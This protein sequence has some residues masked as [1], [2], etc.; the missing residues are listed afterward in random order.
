MP[1]KLQTIKNHTRNQWHYIVVIFFGIIL[2]VG[3]WGDITTYLVGDDSAF[4][5]ARLQ[6][7]PPAIKNGQILAQVSPY[8]MF[9]YGYGYNLFYGPLLP[10]CATILRAVFQSWPVAI[11]V[12][13]VALLVISGIFTSYLVYKAS[14]KRTLAALAGIF[15]MAA[16][17][18]LL[19]LYERFAIGEFAAMTFFPLLMLGLYQLVGHQPHAVR[20]ITISASV[21]LLTH[22]LSVVLAVLMTLM[23]LLSNIK[24][25]W[26][27]ASFKKMLVAGGLALGA[28]A[29]YLLPLA[30]LKLVGNYGVF[31]KMYSELRLETNPEKISEH[32]LSAPEIIYSDYDN[33]TAIE[34]KMAIGIIA[35]I[36]LS[37]YLFIRKNISNKGER[38]LIDALYVISIV[39][40]LMTTTVVNWN[41]VSGIL[42]SIQFPWRFLSVFSFTISIV[43]AYVFYYI[44][45]DLSEQ[46]QQCLTIIIGLIAVC[47]VN[48]IY[49]LP[50]VEHLQKK[51]EQIFSLEQG[52]AG[53]SGEYAPVALLCTDYDAKRC[54]L[55][56]LNE[57]L[58]R[59][60]DQPKITS[61]SAEITNYHKEGVNISFDITGTTTDTTVE[62]PLIWYPGYKATINGK[63]LDLHASKEYG[64][65]EVTFSDNTQGEVKTYYTMSI[66]T[67]IGVIISTATLTGTVVWLWYQNIRKRAK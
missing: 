1:T 46:K 28:T 32:S 35:V 39:T 56:E 31:D 29:F 22:N 18:H 62:L 60:G 2:T 9:G 37:C 40:L 47:S 36:G 17:Y 25:I 53:W 8:D 15:Y 49:N 7:I 24:A 52:S 48:R 30:E 13:C 66:A 51:Q 63:R 14:H 58:L 61:G 38:H 4:Q 33:A 64:L 10:W 55:G 23:Y 42:H 27:W 19:N 65:V 21:L 12:L 59:R 50:H 57:N 20:N 34:H 67:K 26:N 5:I 54:G 41:I 11:N 3:V 45:Q 44:I 16:P 6:S 43:A